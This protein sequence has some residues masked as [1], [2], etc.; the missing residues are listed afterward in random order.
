[1]KLYYDRETA[2]LKFHKF[3]RAVILPY[4]LID[5]LISIT[6][7][8]L[9]MESIL[10]S[11]IVGLSVM[12]TMFVC[13][14]ICMI[15]I[16][17]W[18]PYAWKALVC[19]QTVAIAYIAFCF[20]VSVLFVP[21]QIVSDFIYLVLVLLMSGPILL[22]YIKRRNL[23]LPVRNADNLQPSHPLS[24]PVCGATVDFHSN[25]CFSCGSVIH[26]N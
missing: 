13:R 10:I 11:D 4:D 16:W 19:D 14:I 22:Y 26:K 12:L 25:L 21:S 24:C 18:K 2:P 3:Y 17:T 9:S 6:S 8:I 20:L 7:Y 15:G 5:G 23:F 1:M